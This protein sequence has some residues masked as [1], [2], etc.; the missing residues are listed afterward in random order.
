MYN[1]I[2]SISISPLY[3]LQVLTTH[4]DDIL[5]QIIQLLSSVN[6]TFFTGYNVIIFYSLK[7]KLHFL[8]LMEFINFIL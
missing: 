3:F 4:I 1:F 8:A 2:V 5:A 6:K 7:N